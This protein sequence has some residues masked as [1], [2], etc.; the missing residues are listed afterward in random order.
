[1][2]TPIDLRVV[3]KEIATACDLDYDDVRCYHCKKW[4]YNCGK[5][6]N[7]VGESCCTTPKIGRKTA[8]FQWCKNFQYVGKN[9][10]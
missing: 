8:S 10:A 2:G 5:P 9:N 6:M 7:S 1:M 3:R 4:G